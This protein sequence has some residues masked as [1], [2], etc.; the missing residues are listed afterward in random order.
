MHTIELW[1]IMPEVAE[2]GGFFGNSLGCHNNE[3]HI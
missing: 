2:G 3:C 1:G